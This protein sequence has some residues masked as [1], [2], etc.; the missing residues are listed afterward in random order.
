MDKKI[1]RFTPPI[2]LVLGLLIFLMFVG[3][4][5]FYWV[6]EQKACL[7]NRYLRVM[8]MMSD[9]FEKRGENFP[10]E[11]EIPIDNQ[12]PVVENNSTKRKPI[13]EGI[14]KYLQGN[15]KSYFP[16]TV[17]EPYLSPTETQ[18]PQEFY[19]SFQDA[20]IFQVEVKSF[21]PGVPV[22]SLMVNIPVKGVDFIRELSCGEEFDDVLI[23]DEQA[24][25]IYM[26][27][28]YMKK[29]IENSIRALNIKEISNERGPQPGSDKDQ[30]EAKAGNV[31]GYTR[32]LDL[33]I[34][35]S[36][37]KFFLQ[38]I[39]LRFLQSK[40]GPGSATP[41]QIAGLLSA[42]TFSRRCREIPIFFLLLLSFL[43]LLAFIAYPL[44]KILLIG[45]W[46]RIRIRD[47]CFL[48]LSLAIGVPLIIFSILTISHHQATY[49]NLEK[50]FKKLAD[51][52][53]ERFT[54]EIM[55]ACDQLSFIDNNKEE[56]SLFNQDKAKKK[57]SKQNSLDSLLKKFG[58][59][60]YPYF[61]MVFIL[62]SNGNQ[63]Y[64]GVADDSTISFKNVSTR[65]Y[66]RRVINKD[67][68]YTNKNQPMVLDPVY[69]MDTVR[70]ELNLAIPS[71]D[72][73]YAAA[74]MSFRPL[75]VL[76][77]LIPGDYGFAVIDRDGKVIFHKDR[78]LNLNENFF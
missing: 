19:N 40:F 66:F 20:F 8:A 71:T 23:F 76:N 9:Q 34:A 14:K 33:K 32:L 38:P 28:Q 12:N 4:Y 2:I 42:D 13:I 21:I 75:S 45:P 62:D 60:T 26:R 58:G 53:D 22:E 74:V 56:F 15:L 61:D 55:E 49:V 39:P 30:K 41:W 25:V 44:V 57:K 10:K 51:D 73:T 27:N 48:A 69:S 70:Y 78:R 37:Y 6:P 52:I 5:F 24:R 77:P 54:N 18:Y 3:Y 36:D 59:I 16:D 72:S 7:T 64:K 50:D 31:P 17:L 43:L 63:C 29:G 47:V 35:G 68:W 11:I 67:Y 1:K 46:E 65:D